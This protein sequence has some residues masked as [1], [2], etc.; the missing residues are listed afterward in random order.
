[1]GGSQGCSER[2]RKTSL[3]HGFD[4]QTVRPAA[5]RYT[6]Y[7]MKIIQVIQADQENMSSLADLEG[8]LLYE[9][10]VKGKVKVI[11]LQARCGP[12]GR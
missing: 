6:D 8:S 4:P 11:P 2:V 1:M 10:K 3:L 9:I 12:E 7:T 5:T